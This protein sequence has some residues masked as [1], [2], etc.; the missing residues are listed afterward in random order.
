MAAFQIVQRSFIKVNCGRLSRNRHAVAG[1]GAT[2]W[3]ELVDSKAF[4]GR[5]LF[6]VGPPAL[7]NNRCPITLNYSGAAS[8]LRDGHALRKAKSQEEAPCPFF[9]QDVTFVHYLWDRI[10]LSCGY[11]QLTRVP[12]PAFKVSFMGDRLLRNERI[13]S[14]SI[15]GDFAVSLC[16]AK[17]TPFF[18]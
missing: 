2:P 14:A 7:T 15:R 8:K 3:G 11:F 9:E 12:V 4:L 17:R 1:C 16:A 10:I 6:G 5:I 13:N 18:L